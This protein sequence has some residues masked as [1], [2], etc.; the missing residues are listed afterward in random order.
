M[1]KIAHRGAS[2]YEPENTLQSFRKA[3]EMNADGIELDVH[4][5][6]DGQIVVIHDET[7]DRTTIGTGTVNA[8]TLAEIKSF[9]GN[10]VPSLYEVLHLVDRKALVNIELKGDGT[11]VPVLKI[12]EDFVQGKGWKYK[13]FLLS[14]FNWNA[15]QQ[16]RDQN[17]KIPVGVLTATDLDLAIGFSKFINA[18]TIHPYFHLLD[19]QKT[20]KMQQQ[21]FEV[22]TWTVNEPEDI[23]RVKSYHVNGIITDYPDRL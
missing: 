21:G 16:V 13:Q 10:L 17:P 11:A 8:L 20:L 12:I 22:M 5:S 2:A 4:C 15:L 23:E 3:L 18:E 19:K 14:S 9:S 1:I 7:V 6:S